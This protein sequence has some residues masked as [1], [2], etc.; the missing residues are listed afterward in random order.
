[1]GHSRHTTWKGVVHARRIVVHGIWEHTHDPKLATR[2]IMVV[3]FLVSMLRTK[4]WQYW[5]IIEYIIYL[6]KVDHATASSFIFFPKR[7]QFINIKFLDKLSLPLAGLQW[8]RMCLQLC[9]TLKYRG[10]PT[11]TVSTSTNSTSTIFSAIG[12]KFVLVEF[13]ISKF[14]LCT[15][16]LVQISHSTIFSM[17]QKSY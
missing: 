17:S 14:V 10:S 3:G 12:I 7:T 16:Q 13:V 4:F 15:S 9:G 6:L 1:M 8:Y 2:G 5:Y 11:S